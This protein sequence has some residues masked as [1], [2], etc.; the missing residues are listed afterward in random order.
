MGHGGPRIV[1][2]GILREEQHMGMCSN[3]MPQRPAAEGGHLGQRARPG[4]RGTGSVTPGPCLKP[5]RR[6]ETPPQAQGLCSSGRRW[7]PS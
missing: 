6:E 3:A 5:Q 4:T 7:K 2:T 1:T